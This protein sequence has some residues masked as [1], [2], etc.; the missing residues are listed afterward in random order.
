MQAKVQPG[1]KKKPFLK[2][3]RKLI[4]SNPKHAKQRV[5]GHSTRALPMHPKASKRAEAYFNSNKKGG[6]GRQFVDT[7]HKEL[8]RADAGRKEQAK[9]QEQVQKT[10]GLFTSN[11]QQRFNSGVHSSSPQ[12][13]A[14]K[15]LELLIKNDRKRTSQKISKSPEVS[16]WKY[17]K[18]VK[19]T[20]YSKSIASSFNVNKRV[21]KKPREANSKYQSVLE[22]D[23]LF[24]HSNS[25]ANSQSWSNEQ[26][27]RKRVK[28]GESK[29]NGPGASLLNLNAD[30][31][32]LLDKDF[33]SRENQTVLSM[34][35]AAEQQPGHKP[36]A[37][38]FARAGKKQPRGQDLLKKIGQK[39]KSPEDK[40]KSQE[41]KK[42]WGN[43]QVAVPR[44]AANFSSGQT[45]DG[46]T[47][48][49]EL[50]KLKEKTQLK[51]IK[52]I[53]EQ[54]NDCS[55]ESSGRASSRGASKLA[56]ETEK[57]DFRSRKM[58]VNKHIVSI[59]NGDLEKDLQEGAGTQRQRLSKR[60]KESVKGQS[61]KNFLIMEIKKDNYSQNSS[62]MQGSLRK[63]QTW[64][65]KKPKKRRKNRRVRYKKMVGNQSVLFDRKINYSRVSFNPQEVGKRLIKALSNG[66][67]Q[68]NLD[69]QKLHFEL[70]LEVQVLG[71][72]GSEQA[73]DAQ[74]KAENQLLRKYQF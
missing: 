8:N 36:G 12:R 69:G 14:S 70:Q 39:S 64:T 31:C 42:L 60:K 25:R 46:V 29:F 32:K 30:A 16:R 50:S 4:Q 43:Q 28:F 74:E 17:S 38:P 9:A 2:L 3:Q 54:K 44:E 48:M 6:K 24:L 15:K 57:L 71:A 73:D 35:Q 45:V 1:R 58:S 55:F 11:S 23:K 21:R 47:E 7:L 37:G 56:Y 72:G 63:G 61:R 53:I 13:T 10:S 19:N 65:E 49:I 18:M 59:D 40:F 67:L 51:K 27:R 41:T 20:N 26:K 62:V 22:E 33:I 68:Q 66:G 34:K 52:D 5:K